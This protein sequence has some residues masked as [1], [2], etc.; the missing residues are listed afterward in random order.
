MEPIKQP[1]DEQRQDPNLRADLALYDALI[2][3]D[4]TG[5]VYFDLNVGQQVDVF[6]WIPGQGRFALEAKGGLH[7]IDEGQWLYFDHNR[8]VNEA[9][10][11]PPDQARRG[12]LAASDALEERRDGHKPWINAVLALTDMY[13]PD[14]DILRQANDRKVH[15]IWGLNDVGT[16]L[17]VVAERVRDYHPPTELDIKA[18]A[19]A[20]DHREPPPGWQPRVP[21]GRNVETVSAP[22]SVPPPQEPMTAGFGQM[23]IYNYGTLIIQQPRGDGEFPAPP[24]T[25]SD[26]AAPEPAADPVPFLTVND[27]DEDPFDDA[28]PW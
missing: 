13:E 10:P 19:S 14:A 9:L 6:A 28:P 2:A 22:R 23:L 11:T 18:E 7:W 16:Q 25:G 1:D 20:F 5:K 24:D 8:K 26:P 17:K 3:A 4:L 15:L 27:N 21:P 12:T